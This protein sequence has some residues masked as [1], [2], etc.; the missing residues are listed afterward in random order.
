MFWSKEINKKEIIN[1]GFGG[2]LVEIAYIL[3]IAL[4]LQSLN[5]VM[6]QASAILSI[7]F[8]LLL[9]VFSVAISGIMVF[10]YPAYL[11]YQKRIKEAFAT[12]L[13]T[14]I[15]FIVGFAAL[16]LIIY[17]ISKY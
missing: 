9:L 16:I 3:I 15:T 11:A 4:L 5:N 8:L 2:A 7:A 12:L 1:W 13:V 14:F 10:G 17:F 6:T